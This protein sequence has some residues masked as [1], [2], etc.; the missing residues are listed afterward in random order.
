MPTPVITASTRYIDPGVT[1]VYFLPSVA[2]ANLTPTRV[3][4][5]AGTDLSTQINDLSGWT[6]TSNLVDTPDLATT[7]TSKIAGRTESADSS[8]TLYSSKNGVDARAL[9]P[10]GATGYIAWMDGGDV[11]GYKC[12]VYP[13]TV[14]SCSK[15]RTVSGTEAAKLMV[16]FA[17]TAQPGES[18]TVPA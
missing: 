16:Q 8:L 3:E 12:D 13:V 18:L 1:K 4:L 6:V 7:F 9:L 14:S 2:A 15:V 5:N 10:R 17:I 11:A